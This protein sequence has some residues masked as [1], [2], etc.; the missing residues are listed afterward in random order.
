MSVQVITSPGG[1][2]LVV[3]P[4]TDY[5]DLIRRAEDAADGEAVRRFRAALAAGEEE[6]LPADLVD[7]LLSGEN[8]LR[9]W[10]E[11]RGLT[12]KALA[13][14]AGVASSYLSQIETGKRAGTV[15]TLGRL[16]A[17]LRTTIDDL[18]KV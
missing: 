16:A 14:E 10:R 18:V 4:E 3:V 6:L 11:F 12:V 7:R 13:E 2:R 8:P 5:L 1:E 17:I 9:V 15:E